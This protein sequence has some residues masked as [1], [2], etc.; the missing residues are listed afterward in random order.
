MSHKQAKKERK[1]NAFSTLAQHSQAGRTLVPPMLNYTRMALQSWVNDRLPDMLWAALLVTNDREVALNVFRE[2]AKYVI[3]R[4]KLG[5]VTFEG[6]THSAIAAYPEHIQRELVGIIAEPDQSKVALGSLL[7]FGNLPAKEAWMSVLGTPVG[8]MD[9]APLMVA[10]ARTLDHQSQEATDCRWAKVL[11]R[12]AAGRWHPA[13]QEGAREILDY[14]N[15]GDLRKVRP[16]IRANEVGFAGLSDVTSDWPAAF[17]DSCLKETSCQ[18][19]SLGSED[20]PLAETGTTS[21]RV[22]EVYEKLVAHCMASQSTSAVDAKHDAVFGT[23]LYCL[24]LVRELLRPGAGNSVMARMALRTVLECYVTLAYLIKQNDPAMWLSYRVYGAGQAKLSFLKFAENDQS[25]SYVSV[26]TLQ[27]LA[28]E[29]QWQEYL[30]I[31]LGHWDKSNLRKMSET[32]G[33]KADYDSFYSWPSAYAH[34]HWG[35]VRDSILTTCMNPLHRLHRIPR[36]SVRMLDD[37]LP[38][39]C[40][41]C[42]KILGIV[43]AAYPSFSDSLSGGAGAAD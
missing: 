10:V 19:P 37:V 29:D 8:E 21:Q 3:E 27:A 31:D 38:D 40:S 17:W 12:L 24:S 11:F 26:Q 7:Y 18:P 15:C 1:K 39:A 22:D 23:S 5:P 4:Q 41:L 28:N 32:A 34:G 36:P 35:A 13:T 42:D 14:P 2:L 20:I 30:K 6:I 25:P 33:V 16:T 9:W 43:N